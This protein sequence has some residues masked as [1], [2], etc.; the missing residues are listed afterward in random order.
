MG[1]YQDHIVGTVPDCQS[2]DPGIPVPVP[3]LQPRQSSDQQ[4][5][6]GILLRKLPS[7][8]T[9]NSVDL[10]FDGIAFPELLLQSGPDIGMAA[11]TQVPAQPELGRLGCPQQRLEGFSV[12]AH[13]ITR[14]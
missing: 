6:G 1:K 8:L 7:P 14:G 10:P 9:C 12:V 3:E 4:A 13:V 11:G 2:C 5:H